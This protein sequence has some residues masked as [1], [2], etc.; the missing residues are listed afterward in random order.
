MTLSKFILS[1]LFILI[2]G[3]AFAQEHNQSFLNDDINAKLQQMHAKGGKVFISK[4]AIDSIYS[5]VAQ[6]SGK[7]LIYITNKNEIVP[8]EKDSLINKEYRVQKIDYFFNENKNLNFEA[9]IIFNFN[10]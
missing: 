5:L 7:Y 4:P 10:E 1:G 8:A 2:S 6:S 3:I 9:L